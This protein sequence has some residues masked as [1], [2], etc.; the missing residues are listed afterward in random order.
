[1]DC[2]DQHRHG[3]AGGR[4]RVDRLRRSV[5]VDHVANARC[6]EDSTLGLGGE[7]AVA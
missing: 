6:A 5:T 2:E 4:G 1:M 3:F 7:N